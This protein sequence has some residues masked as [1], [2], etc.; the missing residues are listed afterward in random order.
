MPFSLV[1]ISRSPS[2]S[3]FV[4]FPGTRLSRPVGS[5]SRVSVAPTNFH[6]RYQVFHVIH[7]AAIS[8]ALISLV[9]DEKAIVLTSWFSL[10]FNDVLVNA[11]SF[12]G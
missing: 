2:V 9:Y 12:A 8:W 6:A 4:N 7:R 10:C 1:I 11:K 3:H 5:V